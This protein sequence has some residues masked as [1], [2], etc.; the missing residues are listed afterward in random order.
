LNK[1][2]DYMLSAEAEETARSPGIAS[3]APG[4]KLW[5]VVSSWKQHFLMV[6]G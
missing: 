4:G 2:D 6:D 1:L 5:Q 3:I